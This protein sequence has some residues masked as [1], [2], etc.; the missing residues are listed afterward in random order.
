VAGVQI[1]AVC[2]DLDR[3][4]VIWFRRDGNARDAQKA[5]SSKI[6]VM[7][8]SLTSCLLTLL[9]SL[10]LVAQPAYTIQ[11]IQGLQDSFVVRISDAGHIVGGRSVWYQGTLT[12]VGGLGGNSTFVEDVNASGQVV[13]R[14]TEAN[15]YMRA[16]VW[17]N[18]T[19]TPLP[20]LGGE[21][22]FATAINN[23]GQIIGYTDNIPGGSVGGHRA[24]FWSSSH[25]AMDIGT[26]SPDNASRALALNQL[27]GVAGVSLP[28]VGS[29][30]G[31]DAFYWN[32]S[33]IT[34]FIL[35]RDPFQF[36][37]KGINDL[38]QIVGR[39]N[40]TGYVW[41]N[42]VLT[43][44][45]TLGGSSSLANSI[46]NAGQIVGRSAIAAGPA[47]AFIYASGQMLDLNSLV[48]DLSDWE[49]LNIAYDINEHGQIVGTGRYRGS[50]A[51]EVFLLTPIAVPE[52]S[53]LALVG[54]GALA[55]GCPRRNSRNRG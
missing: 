47:H 55:S 29:A 19:M 31:N 50:V 32:G 49:S 23:A 34:P 6:N 26:V 27:G 10:P 48:A 24:T 11:R 3:G 40:S 5:Y 22:G 42:G 30:F 7:K 2:K 51:N 52:P 44:L 36:D 54:L 28:G 20:N 35:N 38:G 25:V 15:G 17:E 43:D 45:G 33:S 13:G 12:D 8:T 46:N 14:S 37:V 21:E 18:G 53:V 39:L 1:I 41:Q 9:T 4:G 16:F